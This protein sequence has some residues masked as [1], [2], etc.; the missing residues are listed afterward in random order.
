M[1]EEAAEEVTPGALATGVE[2]DPPVVVE[3]GEGGCAEEMLLDGRHFRLTAVELQDGSDLKNGLVQER[4]WLLHPNEVLRLTGNLFCIESLEQD[5]QILLIRTDPLPHARP[6]PAE[7]DI[8]VTL[9]RRTPDLRVGLHAGP[10]VRLECAA[11]PVA[12]AQALQGWQRG[13]R[14]Q[15][16]V[17]QLPG[18]LSN[19]WGDRSRDGRMSHAFIAAEIE[20]A[21]ALGVDVVQLDDGWQK[22]ITINS[23]QAD[24]GGVWEG[25]WNTDPDFWTPHPQ[26]FPEGLAGL[27]AFAAARGIGLGLWFAPDSWNDFMH[28]EKDAEIVLHY[29]RTLG[30]RHVKIDGIKV[31][32]ELALERLRAFVNRVLEGSAGMLAFDLDITAEKRPGYFGLIECGPLFVENRYTDWISYWPH[33]TLRN[34]WQLS[35]WIDPLRLRMEFLNPERNPH[36]YPGD[37]LAPAAYSGDTLFATVMCANP[38]GWFEITGLSPAVFNDIKALVTVWKA[39]REAM[40]AGTLL[41]IGDC[42]DGF[43]ISGFLIVPAVERGVTYLLLFRGNSPRPRTRIDLPVA[44]P[45]NWELLAGC[46]ALEIAGA[47]VTVEI[48]RQRHFLFAAMQ[49]EQL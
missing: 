15:T 40:A 21:A 42:P 14:P 23:T 3:A 6:V 24:K 7:V 8:T 13:L 32:S 12:R 38:L 31:H 36:L 39:H 20:A 18:F 45:A 46:G 48:P 34:L 9:Q 33:H 5:T 47:S 29:H 19:T 2:R 26:R 44:I 41:P 27:A 49:S 17:H 1:N 16:T 30:V 10:W 37:P 35:R 11:G 4:V 43:N 28:W 22:G 25:F